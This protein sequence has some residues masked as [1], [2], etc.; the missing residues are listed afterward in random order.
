MMKDEECIKLKDFFI[1]ELARLDTK[2][3]GIYLILEHIF[4]RLK[5]IENQLDLKVEIKNKL[6]DDLRNK[7]SKGE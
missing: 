5:L 7:Y 2:D 6:V 3:V 1:K 4:E